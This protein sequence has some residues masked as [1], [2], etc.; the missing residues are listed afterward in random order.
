MCFN[1]FREIPKTDGQLLEHP[2]GQNNKTHD[3][4]TKNL[5]PE[6]EQQMCS[7]HYKHHFLHRYRPILRTQHF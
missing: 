4:Y 3:I 2:V 6:R 5:L 1:K 7:C